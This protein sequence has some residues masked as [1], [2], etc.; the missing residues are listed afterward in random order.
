MDQLVDVLV[1]D[2]R[3]SGSEAILDAL[4]EQVDGICITA[5]TSGDTALQ[6][7]S[8]CSVLPKIVLLDTRLSETDPFELLRRIRSGERTKSLPVFL[9]TD[10][11]DEERKASTPYVMIN[12]YIP[13]T[14]DTGVLAQRLTILRHLVGRHPK[15]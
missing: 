11:M 5:A 2:D 8:S 1:I 10:P 9:M 6:F 15:H 14:S 4:R 13:R 7:L 3:P 12:G